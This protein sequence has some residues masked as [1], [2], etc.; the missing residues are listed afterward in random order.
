MINNLPPLI[1]YDEDKKSYYVAL[2]RFDE[3]DD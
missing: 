1:V 2:E 3:A